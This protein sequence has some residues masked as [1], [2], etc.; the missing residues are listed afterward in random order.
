[1]IA[2]FFYSKKQEAFE[3]RQTDRPYIIKKVRGEVFTE[4]MAGKELPH[5]SNWDDAEV[6]YVE[7]G[8]SPDPFYKDGR[9]AKSIVPITYTRIWTSP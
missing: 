4:V 8:L 9:F 3:K 6:V 7:K 1:M 2:T 5:A